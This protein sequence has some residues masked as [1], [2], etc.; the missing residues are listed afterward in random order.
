MGAYLYYAWMNAS[1]LKYEWNSEYKPSLLKWFWLWFWQMLDLKTFVCQTL[2]LSNLLLV[3]RHINLILSIQFVSKRIFFY[4]KCGLYGTVRTGYSRGWV[5]L[6]LI[7]I[8]I[9]AS[10][11]MDGRGLSSTQM[12]GRKN[13]NEN[14]GNAT[15]V[16][17]WCQG[18]NIY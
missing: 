13:T 11:G 8:L 6:L 16:Y 9:F 3:V 12:D 18:K 14:K 17:H 5:F 7:S 4:Y 10:T 2:C 15:I 1:R